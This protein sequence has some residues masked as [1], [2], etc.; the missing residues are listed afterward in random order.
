MNVDEVLICS[1][2]DLMICDSPLY[3]SVGVGSRYKEIRLK[4]IEESKSQ[5]EGADMVIGNLESVVHEPKNSGLQEVQMCC[6]KGALQDLSDIGFGVLNIANNH[7]MQHGAKAFEKTICACRA[8]GLHC[9]GEKAKHPYYV[10]IK[11]IQFALFSLCIHLEWYQ[12]NNIM[13]HYL[14]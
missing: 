6:P 5:F 14:L 13:F 1:V 2:G 10:T 3:A 11:G 8:V 9:I 7:I 4:L 12:P